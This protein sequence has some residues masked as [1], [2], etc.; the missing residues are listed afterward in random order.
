MKSNNPEVQAIINEIDKLYAAGDLR[1]V[2]VAA[3]KLKNALY[4]QEMDEMDIAGDDDDDSL[5]TDL[6]DM[7]EEAI[8][9]DDKDMLIRAMA[10]AL[11]LSARAAGMV[12]LSAVAHTIW[13]EQ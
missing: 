10:T 13:V 7:V 5:D 12:D 8:L 9:E 1:E 4:R 11:M 3:E 6:A 2:V